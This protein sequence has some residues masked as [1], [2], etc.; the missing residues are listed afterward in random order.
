MHCLENVICLHS[1]K[2]P[3][4]NDKQYSLFAISYPF[5]AE[6]LDCKERNFVLCM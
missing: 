1:K 3:T 5:V 6:I 2:K 4:E